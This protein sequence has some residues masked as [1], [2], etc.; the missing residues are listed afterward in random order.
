MLDL[1][2]LRI[3]REVALRGS[4][5]GAAASLHFSTSA[6]SQQIAQLEREAGAELVERRSTGAVLTGAGRLLV[7]HADA[8]LDRVADAEADLRRL[9]DGAAGSV[10]CGAF[11]SALATLMPE[12]IPA[13]RRLLPDVVVTLVELDRRE[14]LEGIRRNELDLGVVARSGL[15][16]DPLATG[17][18][19]RVPLFVESVDVIMSTGHRLAGEPFVALTDLADDAW[20]ECSSQPARK[21]M[22]AVGL[23]PRIVFEGDGTA[24]TRLVADGAAV[25]LLPRLGQRDLPGGVIVKPIGPDPPLR[26]VEI[27]L[28]AEDTRDAVRTLVAV[29]CDVARSYEAGGAARETAL[30]SA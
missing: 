9:L 15:G 2:R 18:I 23:E 22:A 13:F 6:I 27:A 11:S 26:R 21:F 7:Q 12:A 8:I 24:L 16:P 20:A 29:I 10:R 30:S 28:R 17:E 4:F 1:Q 25:C 3:L 14:T 19:E 5:S